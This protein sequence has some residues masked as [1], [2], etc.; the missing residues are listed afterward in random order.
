LQHSAADISGSSMTPA[1]IFQLAEIA[2]PAIGFLI[3]VVIAALASAIGFFLGGRNEQLRDQRATDRDRQAREALKEAE[4]ERKRRK[5]QRTTLL[6]LQEQVL[7][8]IGDNARYSLALRKNVERVGTWDFP[9]STTAPDT[10]STTSGT[11]I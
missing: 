3:G 9:P 1:Q 8:T 6:A 2:I 10:F 5:F 4:R 7:L 11:G